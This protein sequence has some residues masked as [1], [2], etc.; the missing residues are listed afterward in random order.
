MNLSKLGM[1]LTNKFWL[2]VFIPLVFMPLAALA[3]LI[4]G[5]IIQYYMTPVLFITTALFVLCII[6]V[7]GIKNN[8]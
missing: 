4:I 6:M 1:N 3:W 7:V 8:W 5:L 2:I